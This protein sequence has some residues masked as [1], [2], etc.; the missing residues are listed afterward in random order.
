MYKIAVIM[1]G[2]YPMLFSFKTK[3]AARAYER[4]LTE[5]MPECTTKMIYD[6]APIESAEDY[7]ERMKK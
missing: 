5:Q 1:D 2:E 6:E 7:V 4:M 3:M